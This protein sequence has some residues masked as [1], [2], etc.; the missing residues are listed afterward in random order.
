[1]AGYRRQMAFLELACE[2]GLLEKLVLSVVDS[3]VGLLLYQMADVSAAAPEKVTTLLN[4]AKLVW[5][6]SF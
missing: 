6:L 4:M 3:R 1:M 5:I 2:S